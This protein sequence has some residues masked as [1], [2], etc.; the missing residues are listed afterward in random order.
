MSFSCERDY[1]LCCA[2]I[3]ELGITINK[4]DFNGSDSQNANVSYQADLLKESSQ[5]ISKKG[6]SQ[7][8]QVLPENINL[9]PYIS[10]YMPASLPSEQNFFPSGLGVE[11]SQRPNHVTQYDLGLKELLQQT[12]QQQDIFLGSHGLQFPSA[13]QQLFPLFQHPLQMAS[14]TIPNLPAYQ[15]IPLMYNPNNMMDAASNILYQQKFPQAFSND[16]VLTIGDGKTTVP[17]KISKQSFEQKKGEKRETNIPTYRH[18]SHSLG[19]NC[20]DNLSISE[21]DNEKYLILTQNES[22]YNEKTTKA[23]K[24]S[25]PNS[26]TTIKTAIDDSWRTMSKSNMKKLIEKRLKDKEFI[27]LVEK[28]DLIVSQP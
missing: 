28:I 14:G 23:K 20:A 21:K 19:N 17:P 5:D 8:L 16:V 12:D 15:N 3:K 11:G 27:K 26:S 25:K 24:I 1:S 7:K 13:L 2:Y 9:G 10:N 22:I 4:L 6:V 18:N